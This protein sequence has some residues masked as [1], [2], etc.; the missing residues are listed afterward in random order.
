MSKTSVY[1]QEEGDN[2]KSDKLKM[3]E[4]LSRVKKEV[5]VS[6]LG[7]ELFKCSIWG[8]SLMLSVCSVCAACDFTVSCVMWV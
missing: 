1:V 4:T 7:H 5:I 8:V 3:R 6:K 2:K